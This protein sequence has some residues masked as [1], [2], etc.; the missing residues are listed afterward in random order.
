MNCGEVRASENVRRDN[1]STSNPRE[2][3]VMIKLIRIIVLFMRKYI[4]K[5]KESKFKNTK[6]LSSRINSGASMAN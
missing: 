5:K 2:E 1:W 4:Y 6:S 3:Y